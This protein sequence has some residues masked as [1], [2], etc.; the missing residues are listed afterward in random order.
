MAVSAPLGPMGIL[1][2]RNSLQK[3]WTGALSMGFGMAVADSFFAAA[4]GFGLQ[5]FVG[6]LTAYAIPL[7]TLG[8]IFIC[9]L[10]WQILKT[11]P[12]VAF[13]QQTAKKSHAWKEMI[14]AFL[15]TASNPLT[16]LFFGG[17]FAGLI[18][19]TSAMNTSFLVLG[20]FIGAMSWW[21]MLGLVVSRLK[22]RFSIRHVFW[23]NRITGVLVLLLGLMGIISVFYLPKP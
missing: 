19:R 5:A 17:V 13:R 9:F 6:S 23:I 1:C 8:S 4:A 16:I 3:G 20:V 12:V 21:A 14:G 22:D 7:R 18:Q 15:V 2:I 11:H 10:A